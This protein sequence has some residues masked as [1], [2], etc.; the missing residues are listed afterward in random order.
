MVTAAAFFCAQPLPGLLQGIS[1]A[2]AQPASNGTAG[3]TAPE[4]PAP[5]PT[6][7]P[8]PAPAPTAPAEGQAG[9]ELSES[10]ISDATESVKAGTPLAQIA[11]SK[12]TDVPKLIAALVN[13]ARL[14]LN[15]RVQ[16]GEITQA[17]ADETV[18]KVQG[19]LDERARRE[20]PAPAPV[21]VTPDAPAAPVETNEPAPPPARGRR[22][23][24][25]VIVSAVIAGLAL[26]SGVIFAIDATS[27]NSEYKSNPN[28]RVGVEG[29]RSAFIADV[30]FGMAALF[31]ITATALYLIVDE[32]PPAAAPRKPTALP[33]KN[34]K[35]IAAPTALP[36]GGGFSAFMRF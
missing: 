29:E 20:A 3:Q 18:A 11:Q 31:G 6:P 7:D 9:A 13:A 35:W 33:K 21:P 36:N 15:A 19:N 17:Q 14:E 24:A 25:P 5:E 26:T 28:H 16:A 12:G 32:A 23:T 27:K 10:D 30:S 4:S 34:P 22:F 2:H 1:S 8:T